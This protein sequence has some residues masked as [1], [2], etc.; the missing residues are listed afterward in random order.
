MNP[1]P[2]DRLD[3]EE[4]PRP[5]ALPVASVSAASLPDRPAAFL[6]ALLTEHFVLESARGITVTES[7]SRSS[8]YLTMLSSSLVAFGFLAPTPYAMG[9]LAV[10]IPVVVL[11]GVFTYERLVQTSMEDIAAL[12]AI[13]R[14]RRYYGTLLPGAGSYFTMPRGPHAPNEMLEIGRRRSWRG[15]FFTMSSAIAVVNSIVA[16]AGVT[17]ALTQSGAAELPSI[18]AGITA[19][20]ALAVLHGVYQFHRYRQMRLRIAEAEALDGFEEA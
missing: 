13:Q 16:G 3:E 10:I 2:S 17:L 14:I 9:F 18:A 4:A 11:L 20:A 19:A 12:T 1:E 8:L 5:D 7:S 15:I 6:N